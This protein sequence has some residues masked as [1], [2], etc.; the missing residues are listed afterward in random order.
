MSTPTPGITW[1]VPTKIMALP[2]GGFYVKCLKPVQRASAAVTAKLTGVSIKNLRN[3]A[4][5][6]FIRS[7]HPTPKSVLYY[8]GEVEDFIRQTET[9]PAYWTK[10]RRDAYL[11]CSRLR[12]RRGT[13]RRRGSAT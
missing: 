6:G 4:E 3:L 7:A 1:F 9:D 13:V 5:A 12:D 2:D 8:P 11:Q 10:V